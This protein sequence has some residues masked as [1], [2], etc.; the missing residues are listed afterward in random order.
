MNIYMIQYMRMMMMKM[1]IMILCMKEWLK[2]RNHLTREIL[3]LLLCGCGDHTH[4]H[5]E[6]LSC[7]QSLHECLC[8]HFFMC[9]YC[10]LSYCIHVSIIGNN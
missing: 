4:W 7:L 1:I 9:W 10:F 5:I 3:Y 8:L 6:S 2:R